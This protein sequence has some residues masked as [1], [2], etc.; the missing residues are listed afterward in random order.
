MNQISIVGRMAVWLND[1]SIVI[2]I[3]YSKFSGSSKH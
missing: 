3:I 1:L 2:A